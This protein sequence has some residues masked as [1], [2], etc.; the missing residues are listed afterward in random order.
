MNRIIPGALCAVVLAGTSISAV[1]AATDFTFA[2]IGKQAKY[3]QFGSTSPTLS[4]NPYRFGVII[5]GFTPTSGGAY[6]IGSSTLTGASAGSYT[7]SAPTSS[8]IQSEGN[9]ILGISYNSTKYSTLS[10]FDAAFP[11]VNY[12]LRVNTA[13]NVNPS[14]TFSL[15]SDSDY[16]GAP[17]VTNLA[18]LQSVNANSLTTIDWTGFTNGSISDFI[19]FGIANQAGQTVYQSPFV[20]AGIL[21]PGQVY[22][23]NI[24]FVH[25]VGTDS[26]TYSGAE[27]AAFYSSSTNF[28]ITTTP[29]PAAYAS[30]L[31]GA[32]AIGLLPRRVFRRADSAK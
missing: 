2:A 17:N 14:F 6:T 12:T 31:L 3:D 16:P 8:T 22:D 10:S 19:S 20:A 29:E 28:T 5:A 32:V 18:S 24:T 4:S 21:Q 11:N 26:T 9:G 23:A 30:L 15:S 25:I 7:L 13:D 27:A 1:H